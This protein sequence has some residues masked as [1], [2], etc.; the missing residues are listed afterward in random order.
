MS[1]FVE[2]LENM[3]RDADLAAAYEKDP[4]SVL[5]QYDLTEEERK[6]M[7]DRDVE[8]VKKLSGLVSVR[9]TNSTIKALE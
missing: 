5:D 9:M 4:E 2:L 3:G 1:K 7:L 6:A 8:A